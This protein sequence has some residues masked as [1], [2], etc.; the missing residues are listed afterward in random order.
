LRVHDVQAIAFSESLYI[1]FSPVDSEL[2]EVS[3]GFCNFYPIICGY[4]NFSNFDCATQR[5]ATAKFCVS[6]E[7][8]TTAIAATAA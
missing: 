3:C 5:A 6:S 7:V 8:A 4:E 2:A 1:F